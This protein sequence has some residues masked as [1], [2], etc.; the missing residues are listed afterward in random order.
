M[1]DFKEDLAYSNSASDAGFWDAVYRK[2]FPNIV[3]HMVCDGDHDSQRQGIDRLIL[4]SNGQV[5]KIDEKKRRSEWADICIEYAHTNGKPGWIEKDLAIDYLA[6]AFM[7]SKR[8][9]LFPWAMLK[10][11]WGHY[12]KSWKSKYQTVRS[13][14]RGYTTLSIAVPIEVLRRAVSQACVIEVK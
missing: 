10:R 7:A 14:N 2:A 6:Y 8:C 3:N 11:A 4:L 13:E 5:L 1:H 12:G 9:Y